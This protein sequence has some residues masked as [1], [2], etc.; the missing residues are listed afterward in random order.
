CIQCRRDFIRTRLCNIHFPVPKTLWGPSSAWAAPVLSCQPRGVGL[1][2]PDDD[3]RRGRVVT[4]AGD[5]P[6]PLLVVMLQ[7]R[8]YFHVCRGDVLHFEG[9]PCHVVEFEFGL[10][11]SRIARAI[12]LDKLVLLRTGGES[13]IQ[14]RY[15]STM[16]LKEQCAVRPSHSF[17]FQQR[18]Q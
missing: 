18:Q 2:R 10:P 17:A 16:P 5:V 11:G 1:R 9:I 8:Y 6:E 14:F 12:G 13:T 4:T 7:T 3:A 15:V